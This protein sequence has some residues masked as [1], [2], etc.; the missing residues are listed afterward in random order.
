MDTEMEEMTIAAT[1]LGILISY[2][3][4]AG[5]VPALL[6]KWRICLWVFCLKCPFGPV[7]GS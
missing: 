1:P 5:Q 3:N 2:N 7:R 4:K 6:L